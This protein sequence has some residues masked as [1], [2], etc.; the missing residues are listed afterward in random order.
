MCELAIGRTDV[1]SLNASTGA[2]AGGT[3]NQPTVPFAYCDIT[4]PL[5]E[6]G[7]HKL[8]NFHLLGMLAAA[9]A[10]AAFAQTDAPAAAQIN[11][12][13]QGVIPELSGIWAHLTWPDVEPP[14]SGPGPVKRVPTGGR[15]F[16]SDL[17]AQSSRSR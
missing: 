1:R 2:A 6:S 14:P 15:L 7:M 10:M 12:A 5:K 13:T 3:S 16:Q 4:K 9:T 8:W 17:E 11:G